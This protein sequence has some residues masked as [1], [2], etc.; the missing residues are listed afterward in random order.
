[1][2]RRNSPSLVGLYLGA[3]ASVI[4]AMASAQTWELGD[5]DSGHGPFDSPQ[6]F[7][8]ELRGGPYV[9][10]ID[11]EFSNGATPYADIFGSAPAISLGLEVDWQFLRI[12][13]ICSIGIGVS[14]GYINN[15][16]VAPITSGAQ[17]GQRPANGEQTGIN[18]IPIYV[19][20]VVRFDGLARNTPIP[21][22]PY[23]KLGPAYD[24]WWVTLGGTLARRDALS[25]GN[26]VGAPDYLQAAV[27][28]TMGYQASVGVMLRLDAFEPQAAR[29]WDTDMGVNHS[30]VFFELDRNGASGFGARPQ[31]DLAQS[32]W[33]TGIALEF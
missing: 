19:V 31:L 11:S 13:P 12:N 1:M 20:G 22:V 16:T 18:V 2:N 5:P 24:V 8:L 10:E 14:V 3:L 7:A 9:P 21:I 6:N 27:G 30:Y 33:V 23:L 15:S 25:P 4:P 32:S 17:A 29:T 28:G 26:P